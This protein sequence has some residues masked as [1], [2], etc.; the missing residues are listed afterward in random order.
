M[1]TTQDGLAAGRLRNQ[2]PRQLTTV[3]QVSSPSPNA[4]LRTDIRAR[5]PPLCAPDAAPGAPA[6]MWA[7]P[8]HP[9]GVARQRV[10]HHVV[11]LMDIQRKGD[12]TV[13]LSLPLMYVVFASAQRDGGLKFFSTLAPNGRAP[14][15]FQGRY[16]A[17]RRLNFS[18][19]REDHAGTEHPRA[20]VNNLQT[21]VDLTRT[22]LSA[23]ELMFLAWAGAIL[24]ATAY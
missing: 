23:N 18:L 17:R 12:S 13:K 21:S 4:I 11:F 24:L 20:A 6:W 19:C 2:L 16:W 1:G 8:Q 7:W 14:A 3:L 15:T 10:G 9:R 5:F 22:L